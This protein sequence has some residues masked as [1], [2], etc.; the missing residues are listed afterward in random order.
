MMKP[1]GMALG[2][3]L[4]L[5]AGT[6]VAEEAILT[7]SGQITA[8]SDAPLMLTRQDL[9][10]LPQHRM[11]TTTSV[12]DGPVAFK[13]FL[14]RD[15]LDTYAAGGDVVIAEALNDYQIEIP[16]SDFQRFDV[17]GALSMD[18]V[19]LSP[20]DK[21]PIWIVYPRDDHAELQ[22]I[23]YDTRWV[24]QLVSLHVE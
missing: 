23:R 8:G 24:W 7:V 5:L 20:R 4:M 3:G 6:G 21:G 14:M 13:G 22:D 10:D 17:L 1:K 18:G 15:L 11:I 12:T 19:A 16:L 9:L 2:L